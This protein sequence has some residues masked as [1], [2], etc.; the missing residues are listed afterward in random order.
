MATASQRIQAWSQSPA[1]VGR[2][3]M[4]AGLLAVAVG[5]PLFPEPGDPAFFLAAAG[6]LVT[7]AA[8]VWTGHRL[9]GGDE[10]DLTGRA[11][12]VAIVGGLA[13]LAA[14][15]A[16]LWGT[17]VEAAFLLAMLAG[18]LI[19]CGLFAWFVHGVHH[20]VRGEDQPVFLWAAVG[21]V[22]LSIPVTDADLLPLVM[23]ALPA[24]CLAIEL[25][26]PDGA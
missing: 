22:L 25:V 16:Q 21:S 10:G 9:D 24:A 20:R 11:L 4:A 18:G 26:R 1:I 3:A 15:N 7:V 19:A 8:A 6:V 2:A 17:D 13:A 14:S 5:M 23:Y 12:A